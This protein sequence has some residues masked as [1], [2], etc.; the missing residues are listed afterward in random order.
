[1]S[2]PQAILWREG[3]ESFFACSLR[4]SAERDGDGGASPTIL[5]LG[6]LG[7]EVH[8]ALAAY[9]LTDALRED[10]ATSLAYAADVFLLDRLASRLQRRPPT[11]RLCLNCRTWLS[12]GDA[13]AMSPCRSR[14]SR[15]MTPAGPECSLCDRRAQ[16]CRCLRRL[17]RH[18]FAA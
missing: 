14:P 18:V 6:P 4:F 15:R 13:D 2:V 12:G 9:L 7:D 8:E 3:P 1:V 16:D 11:P 17:P 10:H 5:D